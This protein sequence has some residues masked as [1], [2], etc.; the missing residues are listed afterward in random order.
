[1]LKNTA[2]ARGDD[3][4]KWPDGCKDLVVCCGARGHRRTARSQ[5]QRHV[6]I[7]AWAATSGHQPEARQG[8]G[9]SAGAE[10]GTSRNYTR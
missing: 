2:K 6:G 7:P 5:L 10:P 8:A 3:K 4:T 9:A 1:M